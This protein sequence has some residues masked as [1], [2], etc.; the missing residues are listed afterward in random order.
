MQIGFESIGNATI[1]VHD[2]QPIL[3]TDPWITPDAYFGSWTLSHE[4]PSEQRASILQSKFVWFSH[5]HPDHLNFESLPSFRQKMILLPDHLG[6]RIAKGLRE[7]GYKVTVLRD[8]KWYELSANVKVMCWADHYQDSILFVDV[9]GNLLINCNDAV[10][11]GRDRFV[12]HISKNYKNS[13]LFSISSLGIADMLNY[14]DENGKFIIPKEYLHRPPAGLENAHKTERFGARYFVP[15]SSFHFFQRTDSAWANEFSRPLEELYKGFESKK[16]EI[17]PAFIRYDLARNTFQEINPPAKPLV[18]KDPKEFGDDWSEELAAG[19]LQEIDSYFKK[20][21]HLGNFLDFINIRVGKKD[22]L[23][24]WKKG[25]FQ[26]GLTLECPRASLMTCV[27]YRIFE[28]LLIGNFM[29]ATLHGNWPVPDLNADFSIYVGKYA[30][31]G[32]AYTEREVKKYLA[33]YA[34]RAMEF[35]PYYWIPVMRKTLG[36]YLRLL[37]GFENL[38]RGKSLAEAKGIS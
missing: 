16:C 3:V 38:R 31:N 27:R 33:A 34:F 5:G 8:R 12:R 9:K 17:L 15:N 35:R 7:D 6:G 4:I 30:D 1:V 28:D 18:L 13:F 21:E 26:R 32:F 37:P 36:K 14:Y 23:I 2:T 29:K 10:D 19:E 11:F 24:S 20:V 22:N 25:Q